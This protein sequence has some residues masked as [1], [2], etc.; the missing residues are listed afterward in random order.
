[1]LNGTNPVAYYTT[2]LFTAVKSLMAEGLLFTKLLTKFLR[3]LF[4]SEDKETAVYT[5][6]YKPFTV[7]IISML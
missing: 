6:K 3:F 4:N 2:V 5:I 1:M 7:V